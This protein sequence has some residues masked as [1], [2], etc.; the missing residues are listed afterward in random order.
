LHCNTCTSTFLK[1]SLF[2]LSFSR[3]QTC[4]HFGLTLSLVEANNALWCARVQMQYGEQN[5]GRHTQLVEKTEDDSV[6]SRVLSS[7]YC[8]WND[9][10]GFPTAGLTCC[11]LG[12]HSGN[13][14]CSQQDFYSLSHKHV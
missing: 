12:C 6:G 7:V 11:S 4:N 2:F 8:V 10:K 9:A 3:M 14:L 1:S 5:N 13:H